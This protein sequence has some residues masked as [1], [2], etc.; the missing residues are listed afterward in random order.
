MNRVVRGFKGAMLAVA[1]ASLG[2]CAADDPTGQHAQEIYGGVDD[3]VHTNIVGI[4]IASSGGIGSCTGSLIAPNLVLTARHCVSE[5]SGDGIVCSSFTQNGMTYQPSVSAAPYPAGAFSVTTDQVISQRS[6]FYRVGRVIVPDN[7]TGQPMCGRDIALLQLSTP[8]TSVTPIVPRLDIEPRVR[9]IFTASGY[10][11]TNG[12]GS[13]S[14]S[15]RMRDGLTVEHVGLAQARPGLIVLTREEWLA[16]TGTCQGDSGG[17]AIDPIGQVFGVLSRGEAN[18]C[19]SPVY[20][21]VDSYAD[22]IRASAAAAAAAGGYAPPSWVTPP[23]SRPGVIGDECRADVE[24]DSPSLCL[25]VGDRRRCTIEDCTH[26]PDGWVCNDEMT[27]CVPDPNAPPPPP[28]PPPPPADAGTSGPDGGTAPPATM[29]GSCAVRLP[30]GDR[31]RGLGVLAI[32]A[33]AMVV[34][35]RKRR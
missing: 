4:V 23:E 1:V 21:R 33:G 13:G 11:A 14:G 9:E 32:L 2:S 12:R 15:R 16:N 29:A 8:V 31:S 10:G 3:T 28:P 30:A 7:T 6:R 27:Y 20:T 19:N 25:P 18:A 24:C 22:W 34:M 17:P 35:D 26:C 5:V